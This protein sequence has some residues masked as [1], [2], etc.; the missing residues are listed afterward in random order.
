MEDAIDKDPCYNQY[1]YQEGDEED[2]EE[3]MDVEESTVLDAG[4]ASSR[5]G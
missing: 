2:Y 3:D 1:P 4:A 5:V